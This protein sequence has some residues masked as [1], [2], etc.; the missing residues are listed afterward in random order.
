M[1]SDTAFTSTSQPLH[2]YLITVHYK[3]TNNSMPVEGYKTLSVEGPGFNNHSDLAEV[4]N[5][6]TS[7]VFED[8]HFANLEVTI[9]NIMKLPL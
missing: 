9:L 6:A 1:P 3:G 8:T 2:T 5:V 7:T 4:A